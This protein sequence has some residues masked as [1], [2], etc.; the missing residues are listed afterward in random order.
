MDFTED[1]IKRYS[2]HII[3]REVGGKGQQKLLDANV[4]V[5]GAGGLGSPVAFYLAAAG[6]GGLGILDFDTVDLSN[7]QRQILHTTE[8]VG[9]PKV[10][11]AKETLN[12]LNPDVRVVTYDEKLTS[13]NA[14]SILGDYDVIVDGCDN[15]PTRYLINDACAMLGKPNVHGSVL[16]FEGHVT[17]FDSSRGPCY[18]CQYS[19]PPPPGTVPSCQEAGVLG[20][21]PGTIG[22][23]QA[24]E[25][26][27]LVLGIG[28]PLVGRL[29]HFDALTMRFRE[30]ELNKDPNCSLCGRS[31][32]ITE[33]IDYE[34]FCG[35]RETV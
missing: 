16:L 28:N 13:A 1:Q 34:E 24:T 17:V 25:A 5:I 8:D 9:R 2:R 31:P 10:K 27:K 23:L 18:R 7:L 35:L 30:F 12:A 21:L 22:T 3:L 29:L 14:L 32:R 20:I 11:S 4:L 6:I 19:E 15:F 26:I 33:L